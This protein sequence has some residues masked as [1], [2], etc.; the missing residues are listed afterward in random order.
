MQTARER[1]RE[2]ERER[3]L[4]TVSQ[5]FTYVHWMSTTSCMDLPHRP[6]EE[7]AGGRPSTAEAPLHPG[8]AA[9][10]NQTAE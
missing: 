10:L 6:P 1:K 3:G 9:R 7:D 5:V 2:G 4:D 8:S